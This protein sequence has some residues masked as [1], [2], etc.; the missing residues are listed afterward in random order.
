MQPS[1]RWAFDVG[2]A[3]RE[4]L[5]IRFLPRMENKVQVYRWTQGPYLSFSTGDQLHS[6]DGQTTLMV[7]SA[8]SMVWDKKKRRMKPGE[9]NFQVIRDTGDQH[10][11]IDSMSLDQMH[12]L[13]MLIM[14]DITPEP[15]NTEAS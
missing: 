5:D 12:F 13:K 4:A 15:K 3:F 8:A 14:G 1:E 7:T 11:V 9:V 2:Y 6:K 10:E